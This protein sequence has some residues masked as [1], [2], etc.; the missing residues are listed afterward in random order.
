MRYSNQFHLAPQH[1]EKLSS[2]GMAIA[3]YDGISEV[4]VDE[5]ED[6]LAYLSDKGLRVVSGHDCDAPR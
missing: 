2:L 4:W 5:L 1:N 3:P 6:L